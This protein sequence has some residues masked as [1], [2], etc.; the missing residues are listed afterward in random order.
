MTKKS[1]MTQRQALAKRAG[2]LA[3][4]YASGRIGA[5]EWR[6]LLRIEQDTHPDADWL[7]CIEKCFLAAN[8][9]IR[10]DEKKVAEAYTQGFTDGEEAANFDGVEA[11]ELAQ[12]K[13]S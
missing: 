1:S 10:H 8:N 3:E 2:K 5:Q 9:I 6:G 13:P 4:T 12:N 11:P 7:R